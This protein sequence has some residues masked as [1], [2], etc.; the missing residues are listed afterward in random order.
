MTIL[1]CRSVKVVTDRALPLH[2]DGEPS[3]L[4]KEI[5]VSLEKEK[6]NVIVE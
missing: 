2:T 5:E 3:F 6:L 4:S 1:K